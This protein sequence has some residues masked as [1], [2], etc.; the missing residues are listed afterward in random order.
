V[1]E[2]ERGWKLD[3]S[4]Q[5]AERGRQRACRPLLLPEFHRKGLGWAAV[6]RSR[7]EPWRTWRPWRSSRFPGLGHD[8]YCRSIRSCPR[9]WRSWRPWRLS[10]PLRDFALSWLGS[11]PSGVHA[12]R[13]RGTGACAARG[14]GSYICGG[15]DRGGTQGPFPAAFSTGAR[16]TSDQDQNAERRERADKQEQERGLAQELERGQ[17]RGKE[18]SL[19]Q[20]EV[21][22]LERVLLQGPARWLLR[23]ENRVLF[24][25]Q[26]QHR[27]QALLRFD[28]RVPARGPVVRPE[29]GHERPLHLAPHRRLLRVPEQRPFRGQ[30]LPQL[31]GGRPPGRSGR[32]ISD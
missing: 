27:E 25:A 11:V 21:Q 28:E 22:G 19:L 2:K 8:P 13:R 15:R 4:C 26:E 16:V 23:D 10:L 7:S 32:A 20:A 17:E 29:R 3:G 18:R 9:P 31:S 24:R 14:P 30:G 5:K 6:D 1:G 12:P